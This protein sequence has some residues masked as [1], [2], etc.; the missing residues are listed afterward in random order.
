MID[1]LK[2]KDVENPLAET[3]LIAIGR[4]VAIV[5][6]NEELVSILRNPGQT[7][8]AFVLELG[9]ATAEVRQGVGVRRKESQDEPLKKPVASARGTLYSPGARDPRMRCRDILG[10][11]RCGRWELAEH[12]LIQE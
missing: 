11:D 12:F 7:Y 1:V 6:G 4:D 9:A 2:K 3:K 8:L 5:R 10:G